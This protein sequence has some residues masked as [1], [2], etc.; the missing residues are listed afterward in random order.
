MTT[1][2]WM[3]FSSIRTFGGMGG[4]FDGRLLH[5]GRTQTRIKGTACN[6]ESSCRGVLHSLRLHA[7]WNHRDAFRRWTADEEI[8][9]GRRAFPADCSHNAQ[10]RL[11]V[12]Q[13]IGI[14]TADFHIVRS[15]EVPPR[16]PLKMSRN[17]AH[18]D[19]EIAPKS[20]WFWPL[21]P[22]VK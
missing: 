14:R 20:P 9:V 4:P 8:A 13:K 3:L 11:V 5:R 12:A 7:D 22:A 10:P 2:N 1:P 16:N 18:W 19:G 21:A 15:I 6:R 17:P